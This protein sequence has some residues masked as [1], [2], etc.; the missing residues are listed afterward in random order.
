M[1]TANRSP[2]AEWA[3]LLSFLAVAASLVAI[4]TA[5][6][7]LWSSTDWRPS[8]GVAEFLDAYRYM[9]TPERIPGAGMSGY[10]FGVTTVGL[11]LVVVVGLGMV[12]S[13][14]RRRL[15]ATRLGLATRS[16]LQRFSERAVCAKAQ[17]ILGR[18]T[19]EPREVAV[20]L[21]R[22][23]HSGQPCWGTKE[24]TILV[25]APPR[26]G[27][28]SA[29][30]APAVVDH[31]GPTVVTGVRHD[32][33][34]WTHP[35]RSRC[36][37]TMWLCEPMLPAGTPLPDRVR[38]IQWSPVVGCE[39]FV[40]AQLRAEAL[41]AAIPKGGTNDEFWRVAGTQLLAGYLMAA[42]IEG[43]TMS[44]VL[45]WV[46]RDSDR[47]PSDTL[48]AAARDCDDELQRATLQGVADELAAAIAQD[49]RFKAGVSGQARQATA[50]FRL[51][52][53]RAMCDVPAER[54]FD[55]DRFLG[56]SDTLWAL[57]SES[58][59]RQSAG[60]ITALVAAIVEQARHRARLG[61]GRL[62]PPLLLALDEAVNVA[63]IPRLEQLLSTGGGSGI[64]TIVVLQSLAAAR[65]AWG[66]EMG[67]ALLDFNNLKIVLG[68]LSDPQDLEGLSTLLGVREER[69]VAASRSARTGLL[70]S[71][72][73]NYSWR[74]VPV[75]RPDEIR[76][77][78]SETHREA[79]VIARSSPGFIVRQEP[80]FARKAP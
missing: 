56:H 12:S 8:A 71:S 48:S 25:L 14:Q 58:H 79:L 34:M 13:W 2:V 52:A 78:R 43:L 16:E 76:N 33:M 54:S 67:D 37:G 18:T 21:G 57:G 15:T 9:F 62:R 74:Q 64:Q 28:T 75:M 72:D 44:A 55:P 46:D 60:V 26:S 22:D 70:S 3:P 51:P 27:K 19:N 30:V 40:T 17:V 45:A 47:S 11:G 6:A 4:P 7:T 49:P 50:P 65:N 36:E 32:I 73:L 20:L 42:A 66:Q 63:P 23:I 53:I 69:V 77:L 10:A 39:D 29:T 24:E 68:G 1:R 5:A 31:H 80:I 41:F 38:P 61:E 59:Q 35:F